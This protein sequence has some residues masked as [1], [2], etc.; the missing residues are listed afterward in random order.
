MEF[1][2]ECDAAG[3]SGGATGEQVSILVKG[4]WTAAADDEDDGNCETECGGGDSDSLDLLEALLLLLLLLLLLPTLALL[5]VLATA[6]N[7]PPAPSVPTTP[8]E[9][10]IILHTLCYQTAEFRNK[11]GNNART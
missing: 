6:F 8:P 10:P 2:T 11:L 5:L 7:S 9:A 4:V 3:R 1:D